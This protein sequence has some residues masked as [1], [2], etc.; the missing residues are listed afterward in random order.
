MNNL[1]KIN[2]KDLQIKEFNNQRVVTFKDID[3]VHERVEGTAK[4]NFNSN[5]KHFVENIDYFFVKPADVKKY[6]FRTSE[7]NNAG[8][9]LITESGYLMLVKSLS[10]D[11][12]WQVQRDLVNNYFRVK[13]IYSGMSKELQ[14]ILMLDKKYQE[15]D[16]RISKLENNMTIDYEQQENICRLAREKVVRVLGGKGTPAY[17]KLNKKVFSEFWKDYKR[18][19][20][21]NSYKNTPVKNMDKAILIIDSWKPSEETCYMILGANSQMVF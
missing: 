19:M 5:K 15:Q 14:A 16:T 11:L 4:R 18:I 20:G 21:V 17:R 3:L 8:T 9:Y 12:A 2:N 1:I 13:D 6:E 10:D 7:I